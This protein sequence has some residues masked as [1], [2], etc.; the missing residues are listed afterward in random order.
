MLK[1]LGQ[2]QGKAAC[3]AVFSKY[4]LIS[5]KHKAELLEAIDNQDVATIVAIR[6]DVEQVINSHIM[7][8]GH[9]DLMEAPGKLE[10]GE[11]FS[12]FTFESFDINAQGGLGAGRT[13]V[14]QLTKAA[15]H[16]I[17]TNLNRDP[18][19][20]AR[21]LALIKKVGEFIIDFTPVIGDIKGFAEAQTKGDY[22]FAVL[23]VVTGPFGD[24]AKKLHNLMILQ[25]MIQKSTLLN[26][27]LLTTRDK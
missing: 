15:P 8:N 19:R 25:N 11:R 9:R 2:C 3:D 13:S 23:G 14:E 27:R 7:E 21:N 10:I 6:R 4:K 18:E 20:E 12:D 5:D 24:A 16:T 26:S 17:I 1:E 22:F